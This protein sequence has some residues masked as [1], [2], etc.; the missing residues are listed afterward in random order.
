[1]GVPLEYLAL[2]RMAAK[3]AAGVA[4]IVTLNHRRK[5]GRSSSNSDGD[6]GGGTVLVY[7]PTM[8]SRRT[9]CGTSHPFIL[10]QRLMMIYMRIMLNFYGRSST[11]TVSA[12]DVCIHNKNHKIANKNGLIL[13]VRLLI[14]VDWDPVHAT[15]PYYRNGCH[16]Y[17]CGPY[18][19][20]AGIKGLKP[21]RRRTFVQTTRSAQ[22][23]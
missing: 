21:S 22:S 11:Q 17:R 6:G 9:R 7:G 13:A 18:C 4:K 5:E 12:V 14:Q 8:V 16:G 23:Q 3:G 20:F 19:I 2:L 10:R 15:L 1:M